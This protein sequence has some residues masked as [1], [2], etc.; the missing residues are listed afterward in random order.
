MPGFSLAPAYLS[1]GQ[2]V[3]AAP[4]VLT[5]TVVLVVGADAGGYFPT[6]WRL[7]AFALLAFAAAALVA[8]TRVTLSR[9]DWS[10]IAT[11]ALLTAWIAASALWSAHP[12]TSLLEA[13]RALV[14]LAGLVAILVVAERTTAQTIP[15]GIVAAVTLIGGYAL[16]LHAFAS[17]E[18]DP[19]EGRLLYRPIGYA[20]A[21]GILIAVAIVL[22]AGLA[23]GARTPAAKA[24]VLVALA[25]LFPAL[26]LTSSRGAWVA[27]A[28]GLV[29]ALWCAHRKV[30]WTV[31]AAT[32]GL[33][34]VGAAVLVGRADV[35]VSLGDENR[36][37]Y[38]HIAL[39]DAE[40]HPVLGSG[41]GT[42]GDY[43]LAHRPVE[44]F[45]RDAHS[46]YIES[47]AELG[48]LGLLLVVGCLCLP[49]VAVRRGE[50]PVL[51]AA[52][53]AYVAFLV[54]A[55]IDWD[56]EVP[57]VTLSGLFCG[58]TVL[59]GTRPDRASPISP[60]AR[61][62]LL[63]CVVGLGAVALLRARTGGGYSF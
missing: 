36:P 30:R 14:Y 22:A 41:A 53:G 3:R 46:L 18:I 16:A 58:A 51:A 25:I 42:F 45:A 47:L 50:G 19:I 15:V 48:P 35:G 62:A 54:H 4:G 56:W 8:R 13:E 11:F 23:V 20:N 49:L 44:S 28:F 6:A 29:F 52:G 27:L 33:A 31:V 10:L 32:L 63:A 59:I 40:A 34:V 9:L 43:W 17:G 24:L 57:A 2:I 7:S 21:L 5:F 39:D 55:A 37:H 61:W 60:R 12:S 26:E 1:E 38:W